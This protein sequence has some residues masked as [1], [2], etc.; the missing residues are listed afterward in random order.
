MDGLGRQSGQLFTKKTDV[1]DQIDCPVAVIHK[2]DGDVLAL[3]I[4]FVDDGPVPLAFKP[5]G[6]H[7][8]SILLKFKNQ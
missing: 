2:E 7:L 1:V 4:H 3:Q 8:P 6:H 5:S